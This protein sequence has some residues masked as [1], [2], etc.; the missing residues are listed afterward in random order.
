LL[1]TPFFAGIGNS[2]FNVATVTYRYTTIPEGQKTI[3]EGWYG[4]VFGPS[5]L[6]APVAGSFILNRLPAVNGVIIINKLQIRYMISYILSL[7]AIG[8]M[9][10]RPGAGHRIT[11]FFS[12]L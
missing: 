11:G 5:A 10:F 8:A 3:Y 4:A 12:R 7:T 9:F 1:V 2:V 6:L